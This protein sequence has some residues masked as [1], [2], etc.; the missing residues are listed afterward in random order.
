MATEFQ[1]GLPETLTAIIAVA[2]V[3]AAFS[4]AVPVFAVLAWIRHY[5]SLSARM[6]FSLLAVACLAYVWFC[7]SW[8]LIG[9]RG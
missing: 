2:T 9:F 5:W 3:F 7:N 1:T 8:N 6:Y 4:L